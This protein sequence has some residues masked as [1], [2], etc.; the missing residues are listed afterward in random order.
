MKVYIHIFRVE[1]VVKVLSLSKTKNG[2]GFGVSVPGY[3]G[4]ESVTVET[5]IFVSINVNV[6]ISWVPHD[7]RPSLDSDRLL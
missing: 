6:H 2:G 7:R 1:R 5:K 4:S 3:F